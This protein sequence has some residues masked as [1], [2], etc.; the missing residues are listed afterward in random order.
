[1]STTNDNKC[2]YTNGNEY[3]D[4]RVYNNKNNSDNGCC[5]GFICFPCMLSFKILISPFILYNIA[6]NKYHNTI[7]ENYLC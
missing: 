6:K 2:C 1:M 3:C 5:Y 4:F 7:N